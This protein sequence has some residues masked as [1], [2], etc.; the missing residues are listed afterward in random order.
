RQQLGHAET[1]GE[2]TDRDEHLIQSESS[3]ASA[4]SSSNSDTDV[5]CSNGVIAFSSDRRHHTGKRSDRS[6]PVQQLTPV[7][8]VQT[9]QGGGLTRRFEFDFVFPPSA[10]QRDVYDGSVQQQI[11]HAQRG[12]IPRAVAQ[13]MAYTERYNRELSGGRD[14][15][16][17]VSM[18]FLQIYLETIQDLLVFPV[19]GGGGGSNSNQCLAS[20]AAPDRHQHQQRRQRPNTNDLQVRQRQ[21][22]AF[23]V[24]GLS[25]YEV[26]SVDD[27]HAL[28]ETAARNRVLASTARNKTSSRSH[29][30]LTISLKPPDNDDDDDDTGAYSISFVD[31]AGSERVDGALHFLNTTRRRQEL[32]IREA[33]FINR[34]LSALGSVIA[35][36]AQPMQHRGGTMPTPLAATL[37]RRVELRSPRSRA[38]KRK[39]SLLKQVFEEMKATYEEREAALRTLAGTTR[40]SSDGPSRHPDASSFESENEIAAYVSALYS[41]VQAALETHMLAA[42]HAFPHEDVDVAFSQIDQS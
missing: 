33:K 42:Y 12:I 9:T 18:S 35:A 5:S 15:G 30:L 22:Q 1:G 24:E 2:E 4:S 25:E 26:S 23:Y 34:S 6:G 3:D 27:V 40:G 11:A 16:V 38:A 10:K 14:E 20:A 37:C 21:D 13:I 7:V 41:R 31:L 28:L 39:D 17:V 29:T 36:L 8:Y 19:D 32:R